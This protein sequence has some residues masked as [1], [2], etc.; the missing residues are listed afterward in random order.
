MNRL[1]WRKN[2]LFA[3]GLTGLVV[4]SCAF[5]YTMTQDS[6]SPLE[7]IP[8]QINPTEELT[9]KFTSKYGI[10]TSCFDYYDYKIKKQNDCQ[11]LT[12]KLNDQIEELGYRKQTILYNFCDSSAF[13]SYIL[14][15]R[16]AF[17]N[18][19]ISS[20]NQQYNDFSPMMK[21]EFEIAQ[22][23]IDYNP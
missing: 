17:Q 2:W 12:Q 6:E 21:E 7:D 20:F 9:Q 11:T 10:C 1:W 14:P 22:M 15:A 13:I 4:A 5:A 8:E 16:N 19:V 3:I 18:D 23:W